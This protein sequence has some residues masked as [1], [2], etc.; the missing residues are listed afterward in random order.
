MSAKS[1]SASHEDRVCVVEEDMK[2]MKI[3][4]LEFADVPD[5]KEVRMKR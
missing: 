5:S 4:G 2:D 3:P 1:G